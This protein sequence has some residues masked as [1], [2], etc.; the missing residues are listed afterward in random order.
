M[1]NLE[2][3]ILFQDQQQDVWIIQHVIMMKMLLKMM[4][5]VF[6]KDIAQIAKVNVHDS[7]IALAFVIVQI[8]VVLP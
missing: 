1:F 3:I 7:K 8:P 4:A 6:M 5:L 2:K